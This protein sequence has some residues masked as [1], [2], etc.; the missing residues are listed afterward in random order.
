MNRT[1]R[2]HRHL[3]VPRRRTGRATL[4]LTLAALGVA[5]FAGP[6]RGQSEEEMRA[7]EIIAR[8]QKEMAEIDRML[9]EADAGAPAGAGAKM[10][11]T[12]AGIEELLKQVQD[13]QASVVRNIEELVKMTKYQQSNQGGGGGQGKPPQSQGDPQNRERERD[14]D[15]DQLAQQ[16]QKDG[17]QKPEG[18]QGQDPPRDGGP[19]QQPASQDENG[20]A[21]PKGETE[22]FQNDDL[23]GRWGFLPPKVGEV[24]LNLREDEFPEKYRVLIQKYYQRENRKASRDG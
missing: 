11:E 2:M 19:D 17:G 20:D 18:Q 14:A 4:G 8:I 3:D 10:E 24:F 9:Q 5:F 23:S 6:A 13:N 21:P 22:R 16:G 12:I 15:P 7:K 1:H